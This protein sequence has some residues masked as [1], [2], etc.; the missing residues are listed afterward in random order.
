MDTKGPAARRLLVVLAAV[1]VLAIGAA[2]YDF[3]DRAV[4]APGATTEPPARRPEAAPQKTT[5]AIARK[6][7]RPY[8]CTYSLPSLMGTHDDYTADILGDDFVTV[9]LAWKPELDSEGMPTELPPAA[10]DRNFARKGA[11]GY[12]WPCHLQ[13]P[14]VPGVQG[15]Q[16]DLA[17]IKAETGLSLGGALFFA[18]PED[19]ASCERIESV[20]ITIPPL[21]FG[22]QSQSLIDAFREE[23]DNAAV[24]LKGFDFT[25]NFPSALPAGWSLKDPEVGEG[26]AERRIDEYPRSRDDVYLEYKSVAHEEILA[27]QQKAPAT[28]NPPKDCAGVLSRNDEPRRQDC[29]FL[30]ST[31]QK[32]AVYVQDLP[33]D[34]Q[35]ARHV[36][37]TVIDGTAVSVGAFDPIASVELEA[38][39]D[40]LRPAT[41]R[42]FG[43]RVHF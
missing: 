13:D 28:F 25:V 26:F 42:E 23:Q 19:G 31:K 7:V 21:K 8:R 37:S 15:C 20:T 36:Y 11:M 41:G 38:F 5:Y 29:R 18:A 14:P 33:P 10:F 9:P 3:H 22:D 16:S 4:A 1:R 34:R 24:V 27:Y 6:T 39:F 35:A 40:S 43:A 2:V 32:H 12:S 30:F 17:R